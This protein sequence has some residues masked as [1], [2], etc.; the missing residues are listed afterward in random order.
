MIKKILVSLALLL[1]PLSP[2][3]VK[4][5]VVAAEIDNSCGQFFNLRGCD[6]AIKKE[7]SVNGGAYYD[8]NTSGEA[9]SAYLGD[10][11]TWKITVTNNIPASSPL[12]DIQ[13]GEFLPA[14]VDYLSNTVTAGTYDDSIHLWTLT[15]GTNEEGYLT[16]LPAVLT[17]TT[18]A[19]DIGVHEN[20]ADISAYNCDGWCEY[21]DSDTAN[22]FDLAF[23]NVSTKPQVLGA[24]TG[25]VLGLVDTGTNT[26]LSLL[27]GISLVLV[28]VG[29]RYA[30][31]RR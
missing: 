18:K 30:T 16:N 2:I 11:V 7:V 12:G 26:I 27:T 6:L 10:T 14:G 25:Q 9:V 17:L 3:A 20:R 4:S 28:T 31:R 5:S 22:N 24:S 19:I 1:A 23:I 8:A 21:E 15:I 13:V 29:L